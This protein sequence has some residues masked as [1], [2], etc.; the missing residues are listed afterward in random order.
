MK[1]KE[2]SEIKTEAAKKTITMQHEKFGKTIGVNGCAGSSNLGQKSFF[3][4]RELTKRFPNAFMRC[5]LGLYPEVEGPSQVLM[6]DDYQIVIDGCKGACLRKSLE[7]AG[8]KIDLAYELD[9]EDYMTEKKAGPHF[10][11]KKML[12]LTDIIERD[13]KK[14]IE[15]EN[16]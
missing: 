5:P 7:K 11:E 12:E 8:I 4:S 14:L 1:K 13:I 3:I 16:K 15:K 6:Y 2:L 9:H 10:D